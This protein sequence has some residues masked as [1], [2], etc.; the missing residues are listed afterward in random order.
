MR[1]MRKISNDSRTPTVMKEV[2]KTKTTANVAMVD[3]TM[4]VGGAR[5]SNE[6]NITRAAARR[7]NSLAGSP[8]GRGHEASF[9]S[10]IPNHPFF[11]SMRLG[12]RNL[13]ITRRAK[14]FR[15]KHEVAF[16]RKR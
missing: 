11:I 16:G 4:I 5:N 10:R 2:A 14:T 6:E 3:K 7:K 15:I 8:E 9:S 13:V 1:A 12:M